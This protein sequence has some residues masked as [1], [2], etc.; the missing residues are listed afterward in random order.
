VGV[1]SALGQADI[2]L[3]NGYNGLS[4]LTL[5]D[6]RFFLFPSAF[7]WMEATPDFL[8]TFTAE[9][10]RR[11]TPAATYR[12][13]SNN[14]ALDLLPKFDY[15]WGEV[16]FFYGRSSGKFGREVK[17]GNILGE[18]GNDKTQINFGASYGQSN[19]RSPFVWGH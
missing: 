16:G 14:K 17:Q 2:V 4:P 11:V 5:A 19:G 18:I 9:E 1:P 3:N 13:D 8:P 15:A 6:G 7:A 10:P 12:T